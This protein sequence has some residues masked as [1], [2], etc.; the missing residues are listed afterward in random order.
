MPRK[1][2]TVSKS[3]QMLA[4]EFTGEMK[5]RRWGDTEFRKLIA[6]SKKAG[7][8][9]SDDEAE[10][11]R[12]TLAA[13]DRVTSIQVGAG[14]GMEMLADLEPT[15]AVPARAFHDAVFALRKQATQAQLDLGG[16]IHAAAKLDLPKELPP[17]K[18]RAR[19]S[20]VEPPWLASQVRSVARARLDRPM[21]AAERALREAHLAC[22]AFGGGI[23][24][25][26]S[27]ARSEV[28]RRRSLRAEVASELALFVQITA[29][30]MRRFLT[31]KVA[32]AIE[33]TTSGRGSRTSRATRARRG[34]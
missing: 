18:R 21:N 27:Q 3:L 5:S 7:E 9:F 12:C 34:R 10:M 32:A 17:R 2:R 33:G 25:T 6:Q 1:K 28:R 23:G 31:D 14:A 13:L 19:K 16:A 24:E 20:V 15:S 11:V 30:A 29:V 4:R 26:L 22:H 8:S